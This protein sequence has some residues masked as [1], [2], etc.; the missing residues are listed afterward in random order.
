MTK[1]VMNR[2]DFR[3][4]INNPSFDANPN[5]VEVSDADAVAV[6]KGEKTGTRVLKEQLYSERTEE[7]QGLTEGGIGAV[8]ETV[9]EA[10]P[11]A[12]KPL[13]TELAKPDDTGKPANP[14]A[15]MK[16]KDL[17]AIAVERGINFE[18]GTTKAQMIEQLSRT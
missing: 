14:L 16:V 1:Y 4:L 17:L 15:G 13:P 3:V 8:V 2:K 10:E 6:M 7:L 9:I 11:D 18:P 12:P 5:Y